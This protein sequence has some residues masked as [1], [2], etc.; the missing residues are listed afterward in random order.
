M[1]K[2]LFKLMRVKLSTDSTKRPSAA[3][4]APSDEKESTTVPQK[5]ADKPV[6]AN[7]HPVD[8]PAEKKYRHPKTSP[9]AKTKPW[10]IKK[11]E[12]V[13]EPGKTRFHDLNLPLEL[14]HA[15]ADLEFQYCTPIQAETIAQ[16]MKGTDAIGQA[17][18]G[19]GKSAA[20]LI[21]IMCTLLADKNA[22][23]QKGVPRALIIAP[24]R[25][26]VM[27]IAK[28]GQ[29]LAKYCR[30]NI[31]AVFGGMDY[32]KQQRE[33]EGRPIDILAATPG[34]LIDF[35]RRRIVDLSAVK[36]M[37]IDEADRMLD[38]GFI[39]DVRRIVNSTPDRGKRQT[40]MFSATI[41]SDVQRLASQWC[42]NPI[43]V[44]VAAENV[45]VDTV[46]QIIYLA[47]AEEKYSIL[48]NMVVGQ[49]LDRVLVFTNRRDETRRLTERLTR[50][51]IS[52]DM[53]SGDVA[54]K[55]RM[56][57]L[58]KFRNGGIK[59]LVATDVAGRGIHI[60]G[61][62]HVFNYFLPY[63]PEDYVHRIGRTGRAG[64]HGTAISFADEEAA[65]YLPD[66]EKYIDHKLKCVYPDDKLLK[67]PP[68]GTGKPAAEK[69]KGQGGK[70]Y[71]RG[72][73]RRSGSPGRRR[74]PA[75]NSGAGQSQKRH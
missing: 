38:M 69:S 27:Q 39:P 62:S 48:Y 29:K 18:T 7:E 36:T 24:T 54:Q 8:K 25:E 19:T 41:T 23:R 3:P 51:N 40:L 74:H 9:K 21:A 32:E 70:R 73:P 64:H 60:D 1:I 26:L 42:K 6:T 16:T 57:T 43:K 65:F 68:K 22:K 15:I 31:G 45:A 28:D 5:T 72:G 10:D 55:K 67:T 46:E 14:M 11:F 63:E 35:Q 17:Q 58:E 2:R 37:V 33:I 71:N 56:T 20:F 59:V 75:S 13:P 47:T 53:L 50:N 49:K 30:L 12:V 66:I 34:R 61:I 4:A 52:C 44:E